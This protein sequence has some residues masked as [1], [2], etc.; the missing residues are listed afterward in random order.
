MFS[1]WKLAGFSLIRWNII[2]N[3]HRS[4]SRIRQTASQQQGLK[5]TSEVS[6]P[7]QNRFSYTRF[8]SSWIFN[9]SRDGD[10]PSPGHLFQALTTIIKIYFPYS[11]IEFLM[12]QLM[13]M[14]SHP[15][16]MSKLWDTLGATC[17]LL[18]DLIIRISRFFSA[19]LILWP[20]LPLAPSQATWEAQHWGFFHS[21]ITINP[22]LQPLQVSLL[23]VSF[24]EFMDIAHKLREH[25]I[26]LC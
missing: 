14:V 2:E 11:G 22:L 16:T 20:Q 19:K 25:T 4:S 26:L 24:R 1:C 5:G 8:L 12:F 6:S 13:S 15:F 9:I 7:A 23:S 18:F 21:A 3:F 10:S 17:W